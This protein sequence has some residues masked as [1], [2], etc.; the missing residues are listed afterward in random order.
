MI[1]GEKKKGKSLEAENIYI[2]LFYIIANLIIFYS[3]LF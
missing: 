1:V 3:K 2:E